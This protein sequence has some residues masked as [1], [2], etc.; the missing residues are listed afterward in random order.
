MPSF[1]RALAILSVGLVALCASVASGC[2]PQVGDSCKLST[3]C[4]VTGDRLCDTS[5]PDGYCTIFNCEP[6][7]CPGSSVCVSFHPK[8]E[9]FERRFCL[10][11]CGQPSDC[12]SGYVC[13]E[14]S[15]RDAVI[16]DSSTPHDT[17]C[18]P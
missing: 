7:T 10:A 5:Q 12:R 4:S 1:Q 16:V 6:D 2:K 11:T 17:V 3:D 13:I 8:S 14:P 18:L 15:K 9:R